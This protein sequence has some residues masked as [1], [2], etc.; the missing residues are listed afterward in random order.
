VEEWKEL[1]HARDL[2]LGL[3]DDHALKDR[4]HDVFVPAMPTLG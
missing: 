2:T 3:P 4:I 1:I